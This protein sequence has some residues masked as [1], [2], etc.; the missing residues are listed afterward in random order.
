LFQTFYN[1]DATKVYVLKSYFVYYN[2][3]LKK[4]KKYQ[5][6][7]FIQH[8]DKLPYDEQK[9]LEKYECGRFYHIYRVS[10]S[11]SVKPHPCLFILLKS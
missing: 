5:F 8:R 4:K 3:L 10:M 2:A 9:S 6:L 11:L 7:A 1:S